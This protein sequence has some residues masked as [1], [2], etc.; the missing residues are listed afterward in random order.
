MYLSF[1]NQIKH[2]FFLRN[3]PYTTGCNAC[4]SY[5]SSWYALHTTVLMVFHAPQCGLTQSNATNICWEST[6]YQ[7][8]QMQKLKDYYPYP[9]G[10]HKRNNHVNKYSRLQM[11]WCTWGTQSS[12]LLIISISWGTKECFLK[13]ESSDLGFESKIGVPQVLS[14]GTSNIGI[15]YVLFCL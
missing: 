12:D 5:T 9:Q 6:M 14:R 4:P 1:K 13:E 11:V 10:V 7:V 2:Y 8:L 15:I 3:H